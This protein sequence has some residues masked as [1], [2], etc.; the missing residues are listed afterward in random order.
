MKKI[1]YSIATVAV[2]GMVGCS[3][4]PDST[5][6]N[7]LVNSDFET[8][9]G[10]LPEANNATL[11]RDKAHSGH[12]AIKVDGTHEYSLSFSAPLGRLHDTRITKMKVSAWVFATSADAKAMLVTAISNPAAPADKPLLWESLDLS[13]TKEAGKWVEVSKVITVPANASPTNSLGIYL[14]RTGGS[15]PVYL[16]DLHVTVEP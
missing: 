9:A 16:D 13:Q 6:A 8:L 2:L 10:W 5:D 3:S 4:A 12:Y 7:T 1:L 14:W 11:T 15:Q